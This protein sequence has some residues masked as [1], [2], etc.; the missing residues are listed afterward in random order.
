MHARLPSLVRWLTLL[1]VSVLVGAACGGP[2]EQAKDCGGAADPAAFAQHFSQMGFLGGSPASP[3]AEA[4]LFFSPSESVVV[5]A[6]ALRETSTRFCAQERSRLGTVIFDQ[7]RTL[8]AGES[9]T[10]LGKVSKSG[11][12]VVRISVGET[13]VRNLTFAVR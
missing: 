13:T 1:V 2:T 7:T 12:Y 9:R 4:E 3:G 10:D 6:V 11:S 5:A 8:P